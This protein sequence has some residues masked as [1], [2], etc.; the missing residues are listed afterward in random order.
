[1]AAL[2]AR[3]DYI[4]TVILFCIGLYALIVKPNLIKKLI[5][6]NILET[7]VY[8]FFIAMGDVRVGAATAQWAA[9]PFASNIKDA[10]AGI[11]V[12]VNPINSAL[13]LTAIVVSVSVTSVALGIAVKIYRHYG[14]L[15]SRK[16]V[17]LRG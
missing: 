5:G 9:A 10:M 4:V 7:S 14:T 2:I 6:L 11:E 1:M 8:L 17:S 13:I 16:I 12:M 15:D 3:L